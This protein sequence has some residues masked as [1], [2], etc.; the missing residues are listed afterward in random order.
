MG[1]I[2]PVGTSLG[3][4]ALLRGTEPAALP[5]EITNMV[6]EGKI[7]ETIVDCH[8]HLF[9][10]RLFEAIWDFFSQG[11]G[12][13]VIHRLYWRECVRYLRE[14][15]VG[16]ILYSNYAHK[17]GVAQSLNRWN[18]EVLEESEDLYCFCPYHPDDTDGIGPAL[19]LLAHPRVLGFKLQ[20]LVQC[21]YPH[22][23]RLFPLYEAVIERKKRMLL[24]VGNGPVGNDF[25]GLDNFVRLMRRYP[26]L[27]VTVAHMGAH[28]Y[29]AFFDLLDEYPGLMF[30]TSFA[31]LE[32]LGHVCDVPL[33]ELERHQDRIVYGS[34]FP[35]LI[36]PREEE[37][38]YLARMG[39]S[40]EFYRKVFYENG[41]RLITEGMRNQTK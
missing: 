10:D 17:Q 31:F 1:D 3:E 14:K 40:D 9:P 37:I 4:S 13:D 35:N 38:D 36:I 41:M 12:W 15:G 24:H 7:P 33:K 29:R 26:D 27:S 8:V 2:F 32:R 6:K 16:P 19:E 28:E 5:G 34:D 21:F 30:D 23:E 22:D 25:V 11:Y 39:L 18:I 20:L